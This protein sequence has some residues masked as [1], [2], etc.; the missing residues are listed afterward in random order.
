MVLIGIMRRGVPLAE[1]IA[2]CILR[3][4]GVEIEVG[5]LDITRYRDDLAHK[6]ELPALC[7][8]QSPVSV[9]GKTVILVDDVL[10]TGRTVR[11]ALE[12][13][14]RMGRPSAVRL[15]VLIDRGLRE[16]PFRADFVGKNVPTSHAE[17]VSVRLAEIDGEDTVVILGK[18]E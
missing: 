5:G 11:A 8:A 7:E 14:F 12:G 15:A 3:I 1:R 4:E 17:T 18:S 2:Q 9:D 16:L 6:K 10:F 13:L